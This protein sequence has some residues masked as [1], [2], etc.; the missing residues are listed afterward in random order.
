MPWCGWYDVKHFGFIWAELRGGVLSIFAQGERIGGIGQ[1]S[2]SLRLELR[3]EE[4]SR[5]SRGG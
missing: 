5:E 4:G 1:Y 2:G 3:Y